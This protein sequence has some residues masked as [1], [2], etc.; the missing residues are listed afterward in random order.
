MAV[1]P[2]PRFPLVSARLAQH[3]DTP[4]ILLMTAQKS[5]ALINQIPNGAAARPSAVL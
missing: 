3:P 4:G 2:A 1:A 5:G